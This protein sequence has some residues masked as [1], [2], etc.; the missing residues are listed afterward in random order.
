VTFAL[1]SMEDADQLVTLSNGQCLL[2]RANDRLVELRLEEL[3]ALHRQLAARL[4]ALEAA[5]FAAPAG[6]AP[7]ES[8]STILPEAR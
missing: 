6:I 3:E 4:F 8:A 1:A 7:I 2:R 5:V